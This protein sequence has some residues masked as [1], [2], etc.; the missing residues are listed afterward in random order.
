MDTYSAEAASVRAPLF[1]ERLKRAIELSGLNLR[2][3]QKRSAVD[4]GTISLWTQARKGEDGRLRA[5]S[6]DAVRAVAD[7][8]G[9][10]AEYL[11]DLPRPGQAEKTDSTDLL[12][13]LAALRA[14]AE[15]IEDP[16]VELSESL[17]QNLDRFTTLSAL[18][19]EL[20]ELTA[21]ARR[22]E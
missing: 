13:R 15:A 14:K 7:V 9:V 12:R 8:L 4:K 20:R 17:Q 2:D 11:L 16:A 18:L 21:E 1:A 3:L 10:E 5:V 22:L 19:G 6:V